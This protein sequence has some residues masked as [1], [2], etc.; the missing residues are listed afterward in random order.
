MSK[1]SN[2]TKENIGF[3]RQQM[4]D[5][6]DKVVRATNHLDSNIQDIILY[7]ERAY[8]GEEIIKKMEIDK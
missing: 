5:L 2:F 6:R 8:R 4:F 3:L 7:M 1:T